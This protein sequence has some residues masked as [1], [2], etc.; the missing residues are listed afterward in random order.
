MSDLICITPY[1]IEL[2][3]KINSLYFG[4]DIFKNDA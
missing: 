1:K 4:Y 3:N 2:L